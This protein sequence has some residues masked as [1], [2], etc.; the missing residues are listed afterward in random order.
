[1]IRL[2]LLGGGHAH[3]EVL[4]ELAQ[5]P[6]PEC[7]IALVS[8]QP[9]QLYSG[10]IPGF[11]AGH[12]ALADCAIDLEALAAR[13]GT[14]FHRSNASLVSPHAR[15]VMLADG[16]AV[17]YDVLSMDVGAAVAG[18]DAKGV[19]RHA[20]VIRPLA[21]A[22]E[23]WTRVL[24]K[25]IDGA[26]QSVT[27]VGGG[28][29]GVELALAMDYRFRVEMGEGAPHTRVIT[30]RATLVSEFPAGARMRLQRIL[31][32]RNIGVHAGLAVAEVGADFVRLESGLEF[33]T[34]ATFWATGPAA[35]EWI[36]DS[37]LA[38]D[39]QGYLLVNDCLQSVA[40][41]EI[42]AAGDCATRGDGPLPKSG[43]FAVRAGPIL[44]ANLRAAMNGTALESH[45]T[46]PRYLALVS[47]GPRRAIGVWNG[48]SWEGGWV[49][50]WKDRIDRRFVARYEK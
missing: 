41:P 43:V 23:G 5:R 4:R 14:R 21:A 9:R 30:D 48:F 6:Q 3:V 49:W 11:I 39:S 38:T 13:A 40:C 32:E 22:V 28:A 44:A 33:A 26:I 7:E 37:G 19:G 46:S 45:V 15:E 27:M 8:P 25:A 50:R 2:V 36:R 18:S 31:A 12:Y 1:M 35:P 47:E 29:A 34:G 16:T 10:M 20:I 42:F 17:K 24:G